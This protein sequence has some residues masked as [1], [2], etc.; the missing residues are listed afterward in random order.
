[1]KDLDTGM[2]VAGLGEEDALIWMRK[3]K[4]L[5]SYLNDFHKQLK[6]VIE[7]GSEK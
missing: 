6:E 5:S 7:Y 1:M 4:T 2:V 3:A